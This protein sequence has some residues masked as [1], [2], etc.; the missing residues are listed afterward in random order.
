M[1]R[2]EAVS[3]LFSTSESG[4]ETTTGLSDVTVPLEM[5]P[6]GE[7]IWK[8]ALVSVMIATVMPPAPTP[9]LVS[10]SLAG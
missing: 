6:A 7:V 8:F 2:L 1:P 9:E 5:D 3:E 10:V 4:I